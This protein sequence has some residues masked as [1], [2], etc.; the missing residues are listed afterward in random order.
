MTRE[1]LTITGNN[2]AQ[3][4]LIIINLGYQMRKHEMRTKIPHKAKTCI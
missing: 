2:E 4:R 1:V 3:F